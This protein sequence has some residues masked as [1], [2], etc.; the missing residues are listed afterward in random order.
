MKPLKIV[1]CIKPVP[2][3]RYWDRLSLDPDTK[4]LRREGIPIV[5]SPLDKNAIEEALRIKEARGG[6]VTVMSMGPPNT[7]EILAWAYAYGVDDAVLLTDRAFAGEL[8]RTRTRRFV[9]RDA[10]PRRPRRDAC[11]PRWREVRDDRLAGF[12]PAGFSG[13]T[14]SPTGLISKSKR[15]YEKPGASGGLSMVEIPPPIGTL[16]RS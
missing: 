11:A 13:T 2:A 14:R 1:V 9:R 10:S 4:V 7:V 12:S 6:S 3:S 16:Y 5:I 15:T 8:P